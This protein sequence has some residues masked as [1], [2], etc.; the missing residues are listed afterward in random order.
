MD[1]LE[2]KKEVFDEGTMSADIA[3]AFDAAE[4]KAAEPEAE[5]PAEVTAETTEEPEVEEPVAEKPEK[6]E[7]TEKDEKPAKVDDDKPP[8]GLS[9]TARE[10]WKET[11]K[12]IKDELAKRERDYAKGLQKNAE[13]AKRAEYMDTVLSGH[14]RYLQSSGQPVGAVL[15]NLLSVASTLQFAP[16]EQRAA[17]IA[18]LIRDFGVDIETLDNVLVSRPAPARQEAPQGLTAE[19]VMQIM[20]Q[21]ES[22]SRVSQTLEQ[23]ANTHEFYADVR[24]DMADLL[25]L[26]A[27]RG[28]EM[29]LD[30]AYKKACAMNDEIV[31]V[32]SQ[33][34]ITPARRA[35]ASSIR[36]NPGGS[37]LSAGDG[38]IKGDIERAIE[39][40]S[41]RM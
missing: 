7:K 9:A 36:G 6:A 27:K 16:Q 33:R 31:S 21:R 3:A 5:E 8:V 24:G 39:R 13:S 15:N 25:D 14:A 35:A 30:E 12:A 34:G 26:A 1:I 37:G 18:G 17:A 41:N 40:L 4:A 28:Q 22:Q 20:E 23:F 2:D 19:Q 29:T 32:T 11:P 38:S 10:A